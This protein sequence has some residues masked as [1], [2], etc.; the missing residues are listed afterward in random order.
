MDGSGSATMVALASLLSLVVA[1]TLMLA[2]GWRMPG[3]GGR[4]GG[5]EKAQLVAAIEGISAQLGELQ[6][7]VQ[8]LRRAHPE[9]DGLLEAHAALDQLKGFEPGGGMEAGSEAPEV[10]AVSEALR[11]LLGGVLIDGDL[12]TP[13]DA[14]LGLG[15]L[16][17]VGR[18]R[19]LVLSAGITPSMLDLSE[20]EARRL[21][22][23]AYRSGHA[24]WARACYESS[25]MHSPMHPVTLSA[26]MHIAKEHGRWTDVSALLD[27]RLELEPDDESLLRERAHLRARLGDLDAARDVAR[28][29]ALGSVTAA[30]RSL[31][32]GIKQRAGERESALRAVDEA[33]AINPLDGGDWRRKAE[34]HEVLEQPREALEAVD[35]ALSLDR[36]DGDAW[37]IRGRLLARSTGRREEALK[38]VVHAAALGAGGLPVILLKAQL[39]A[40]LDRMID[41]RDTLQSA[42]DE[43]PDEGT[44][45][46]GL[47]ELLARDGHLDAALEELDRAPEAALESPDIHLMRGRLLVARADRERD[48]EGG[49]DAELLHQAGEAFAQAVKVD[50]EHGL[51]W[52][53]QARVERHLGS[54][55]SARR[56][57]ER[58]GRLLPGEGALDAELALLELDCNDLDAALRAIEQAQ[59][60]GI[61]GAVVPLVKGNIAGRAGRVREARHYYDQVLEQDP[62]H[63]RARLN[64]AMVHTALGDLWDALEDLDALIEAHPGL[65][66][67]ALRKAEVLVRMGEFTRAEGVVL[68]VLENQPHH[69]AALRLLGATRVAQ[70]RSEEALQPLNEAI[71]L[72]EEDAASWHQRALAYL[73]FGQED[74]A[75]A[76]L[77]RAL[78][79][80]PK[81][82]DALLHRAAIHHSAE[83]WD[84]AE[85]A[86]RAVL[87]TEPD[88]QVA[89]QRMEQA[90]TEQAITA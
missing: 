49:A 1:P 23:L 12:D 89:R 57:L 84:D 33:L 42:V 72:A 67:A 87:D 46:A 81:H 7:G 43:Q 24:D 58:A 11:A 39:L 64:R 50:R 60:R 66:L 35:Q 37:A 8:A 77:E 73:E 18:L 9:I 69:V 45:R 15:T 17:L 41:A 4:R 71:A 14:Q 22:E 36:Q 52:L 85:H 40:D 38:A 47:A 27:R 74:A 80:E 75:L 83:R 48:G 62:G 63:V 28:L 13:R 20:L 61:E 16:R 5:G 29:E 54:L 86:W 88:H 55:D 70:G 68:S 78:K 6:A 56:S 44:L 90:T 79:H 21:G 76:D 2:L 30:D 82:L 19:E 65:I 10:Q 31:L 3:L 34:L 26:L 53:G 59:L 51:A 25:L 32:S